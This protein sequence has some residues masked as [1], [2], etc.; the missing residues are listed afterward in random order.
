MLPLEMTGESTSADVEA[1][2]RE[3]LMRASPA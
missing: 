2:P 1:L 3:N